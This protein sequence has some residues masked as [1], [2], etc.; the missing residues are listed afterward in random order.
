MSHVKGHG[1]ATQGRTAFSTVHTTH[2]GGCQLLSG[3]KRAGRD[4][5]DLA[6]LPGPANN[7]MQAAVAAV[8]AFHLTESQ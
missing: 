6:Q 5:R 1:A 3:W 8:A 7:E 4:V 2:P